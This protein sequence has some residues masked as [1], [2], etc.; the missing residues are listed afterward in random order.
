MEFDDAIFNCY[1][2]IKNEIYDNNMICAQNLNIIDFQNFID[3]FKK[4]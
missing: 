3:N 4:N 2:D 1:K